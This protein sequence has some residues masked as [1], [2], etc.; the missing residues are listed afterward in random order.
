[1]T[2]FRRTLYC[3][4]RGFLANGLRMMMNSK[5]SALAGWVLIVRGSVVLAADSSG[6]PLIPGM[7]LTLSDGERPVALVTVESV[8]GD[9]ATG[10]LTQQFAPV[11]LVPGMTATAPC[12]IPVTAGSGRSVYVALP[13]DHGLADGTLLR[14]LRDGAEI[15]SA[16]L[17]LEADQPPRAVSLAEPA[18]ALR[19]GDLCYALDASAAPPPQPSPAAEAT[20]AEPPRVGSAPEPTTEAETS[21]R[22]AGPEPDAPSVAQPDTPA[23]AERPVGPWT[24]PP[25]GLSLSGPTGILR[26]PNA[27]VQPPGVVRM[28]RTHASADLDRSFP[29]SRSRSQLTLGALP[30]LEI[31]IAHFAR[32][33][34]DLTYHAK[35]QLLPET[36]RWP[37]IA[38]GTMDERAA[39]GLEPTRFVAAGKHF[40]RVRATVGYADGGLDGVFGGLEAAVTPRLA[41]LAEYDTEG[42]N[43]GLRAAPH[44]RLHIDLAQLDGTLGGQVS[45]A[46]VV[47]DEDV[48]PQPVR[49]PRPESPVAPQV[50]AERLM[51]AVCRLG[52]ENVRAEVGESPS[53]RAAVVYYENRRY[54]HDETEA[55]GRVLAAVARELPS[56]ITRMTAI[57][58]KSQTPVLRVTTH[59]GDYVRFLA[60]E[61]SAERYAEML[62]VDHSTGSPI[63]PD[64]REG[65][66]GPGNPTRRSLDLA[67]TPVI[68][69]L[70][71]TERPTDADPDAT[72]SLAARLALRP[73]VYASLGRGL[74]LR[75]SH[76]VHVAGALGSGL[77]PY[78]AGDAAYASYLF[79]PFDGAFGRVAAGDFLGGRRGAVAEGAFGLCDDRVLVRGL[80]GRL[81]D[82]RF[83]D[84]DESHWVWIGD[85]RYRVPSLDLVAS[86]TFGRYLDDDR[87]FTLALRKHF[88]DTELE[89]QFR[90]SD[91]GNVLLLAGVVPIGPREWS[92][93]DPMRVRLGDRLRVGQRALL[94]EGG[95]PGLVTTASLIA[96]PLEEFDLTDSVL[97][98]DRLNAP[99]LRA[100]LDTLLRAAAAVAAA[101]AR[102]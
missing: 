78:F 70:I 53:G 14:V 71:G 62:Q 3:A 19:P 38:V 20:P 59:P 65:R 43:Y 52:M 82:R 55:L 28:G 67:L 96:N 27:E 50:L 6:R 79:R 90:H 63:P 100:H 72:Q 23:A 102:P 94:P 7:S 97:N 1:M 17:S 25:R 37:A 87:G 64:R 89:M 95:E 2:L 73:D 39:F 84:T 40:G 85:I 45:Y 49:L 35:L 10:T 21:V 30:R 16:A 57:A 26:T 8:V 11:P 42:L 81:A 101:D 61:L 47:D 99:Y 48:P 76:S 60:G 74:D 33:E 68:R 36:R 31:G 9:R 4:L 46:F 41:L 80:T 44:P 75:Y 54:V 92:R 13:L 18:P 22:A 88:E 29:G 77:D 15:G 93:P 51:D 91:Y 56:D 69:T 5:L 32:F 66:S 86:T 24:S 83:F 58:T 98:R 34:E 12:P